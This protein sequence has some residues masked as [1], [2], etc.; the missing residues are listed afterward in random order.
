[1]YKRQYAYSRIRNPQKRTSSVPPVKRT[2]SWI[3]HWR[4]FTVIHFAISHTL[5]TGSI[6][7]YIIAG[8][9]SEVSEEV[10]TRI[11]KNCS[12][13][14]PHSDHFHLRSPPRETPASIHIYLIFPETSH[15]PTFLSLHVWVYL[16][17]KLCSGLKKTHLFCTRVRFGR[18]GSSKVDDFGTCY[19]GTLSGPA[20][21]CIFIT[22]LL[23]AQHCRSDCEFGV[24][25]IDNIYHKSTANLRANCKCHCTT[26]HRLACYGLTYGVAYTA[27]LLIT[28]DSTRPFGATA[29][30]THFSRC[31]YNTLCLRK[32]HANF[33]TV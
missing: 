4:S 29:W 32:K 14:Q 33:E 25:L 28:Q 31:I 1:M 15:W 18:S 12:R 27:Y 30:S 8:F 5:T 2:L 24:G 17:L 22:R 9:I 10:A 19:P 20:Y 3:R 16:H 23:S 13:Q 6:S 26:H 21:P 7:S 11:A